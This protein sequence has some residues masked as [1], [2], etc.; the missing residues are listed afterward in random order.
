MLVAP[1]DT[2][3]D[4]NIEGATGYILDRL[5]FDRMIAEEAAKAGAYIMTDV[6]AVDL[7]VVEDSGRF[8]T[9]RS[10]EKRWDVKAKIVIAADGVESR[11]ARW[12][13]LKTHVRPHDMET[14]A[15]YTLAGIDF[16]P[17]RFY[18]YFSDK[19][20]PG[21]YAWLFPKGEHVANVGLGISGDYSAEKRPIT[22][23]DEFISHYFHGSS[24][25][26]RTIGGVQCSGGIESIYTD[27]LMVVGDAAHMANPVTGGG[28]ATALQAG[29][30]AGEVAKEAVDNGSA[31]ASALKRYEKLVDKKFGAMNRRFY[32]LKEAIFNVPDE[33]K[34]E[35]ARTMNS[36]PP[37]Q[38]TPLRVLKETLITQPELLKLVAKVVL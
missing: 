5:I 19:F 22:Y 10:G 20:A 7:S 25:V 3:V 21:G 6:E 18:L 14:C 12:A 33:K 28:I 15:Q 30:I 36:L 32:K 9:L 8:V 11:V 27:N 1:D 31:R 29:K 17:S 26:S 23:L 2:E 38:R 37:N 35:L 13:G 24:I 4:M 16:D 34:N